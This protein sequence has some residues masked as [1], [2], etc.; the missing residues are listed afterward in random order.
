MLRIGLMLDSFTTS[1]WIEKIVDDIQSSDFARVE[2]VI[3]NSPAQQQR[4]SFSTR[5]KNHWKRT[6][7]H[8]YEKADYAKHKSDP[9]FRASRDLTETLRDVPLLNVNPVCK[10]FT[11]RFNEND[12][13][14]IR[15]ANLDVIFRFGFRIIRGEI[16]QIPRHGVWSFHHDD[17]QEYRGGPPLFW[18]IKERNPVSGTILQVLTD[19][20]DG[21][22]VIY[23]GHSSTNFSSLYLNRNP[24]Y[25]KTAEYAMRRL[26]DLHTRGSEYLQSQIGRAHV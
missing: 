11:D 1:A 21:G 16:L 9:D 8:L 5:L 4:P 7:F 24:I 3:M 18:E 26:R 25:W 19:S 14:Q 6:L 15:A 17:N 10:G 2:M 20:L 12:I 22:R 13:A 23:R